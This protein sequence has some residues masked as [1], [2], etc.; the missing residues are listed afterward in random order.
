MIERLSIERT[1]DD[2]KVGRV[3]DVALDHVDPPIIVPAMLQVNCR[4]LR[5][6]QEWL[7]FLGQKP[8]SDAEIERVYSDLTA[9]APGV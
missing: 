6:H 7:A 1:T 9:E 2:V 3:R 4:T 5:Q 8:L